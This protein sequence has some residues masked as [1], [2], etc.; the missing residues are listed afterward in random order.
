MARLDWRSVYGIENIRIRLREIS[1]SYSPFHPTGGV[2]DAEC[3]EGIQTD[4][5]RSKMHSACEPLGRI[6]G[7]HYGANT[8]RIFALGYS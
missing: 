4:A 5:R 2:P 3:T 6:T 8:S 7:I 1:V